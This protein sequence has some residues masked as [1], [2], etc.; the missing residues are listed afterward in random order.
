MVHCPQGKLSPS[1]LL[2]DFSG[3]RK[4]TCRGISFTHV[5]SHVPDQ[6]SVYADCWVCD[7][8]ELQ[9][10]GLSK[11]QPDGLKPSGRAHPFVTSGK[12][13][14]PCSFPTRMWVTPAHPVP[15]TPPGVPFPLPAALPWRRTALAGAAP[16]PAPGAL[17]T[18][19]PPGFL[20]KVLI[21]QTRV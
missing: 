1:L 20:P 18:P 4:L 15:I 12:R 14:L 9:T 10:Q 16:T 17:L 11:E 7:V 3:L 8:S 5:P 13:P 2:Y 6:S 19:T 21:F